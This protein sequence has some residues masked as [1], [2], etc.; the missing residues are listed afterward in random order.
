LDAAPTLLSYLLRFVD[1]QVETC[2]RKTFAVGIEP[3][4]L[5]HHAKSDDPKMSLVQI[6]LLKLKQ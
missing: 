3:E 2:H 1:V 6:R 4:V 5:S